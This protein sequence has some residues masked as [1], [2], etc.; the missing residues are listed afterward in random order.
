M[1]H[2]EKTSYSERLTAAAETVRQQR[3]VEREAA[4]TARVAAQELARKTAEEA[5][6]LALESKRNERKERK[7]EERMDAQARRAARMAAYGRMGSSS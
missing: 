3:V 7:K 4:K 5:T 6:L 1:K 2:A